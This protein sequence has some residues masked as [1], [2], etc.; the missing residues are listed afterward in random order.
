[1]AMTSRWAGK[2]TL[3]ML[4]GSTAWHRGNRVSQVTDVEEI[5]INMQE[6]SRPDPPCSS[7]GVDE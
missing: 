7:L 6:Q 1:M 3:H 2:G 5:A 4:R